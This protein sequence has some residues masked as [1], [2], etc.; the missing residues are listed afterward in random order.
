MHPRQLLAGQRHSKPKCTSSP[1]QSTACMHILEPRGSHPLKAAITVHTRPH[2][3]CDGSIRVDMTLDANTTDVA[4]SQLV[5]L[6]V[7]VLL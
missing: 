7:N 4:C 6:G 5:R 1:A 3:T 2:L